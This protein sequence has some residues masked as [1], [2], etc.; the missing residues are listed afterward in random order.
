MLYSIYSILNQKST[1]HFDSRGSRCF[2]Y[3]HGPTKPPR[4]ACFFLILKYRLVL[5]R[6][7]KPFIIRL[8]SPHIAAWDP[9]NKE[10]HV[11]LFFIFP[12]TQSGLALE[13]WKDVVKWNLPKDPNVDTDWELALISQRRIL[14]GK[15]FNKGKGSNKAKGRNKS[16]DRADKCKALHS[17]LQTR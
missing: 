17:V 5:V 16:G 12:L 7:C 10:T 2:Y 11:S 3:S 8:V 9:P 1:V 6:Y 14:L 13:T 4:K 15:F